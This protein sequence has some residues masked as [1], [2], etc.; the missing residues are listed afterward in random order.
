[1]SIL[2]VVAVL[3]AIGLIVRDS[4]QNSSNLLDNE[5]TKLPNSQDG[6]FQP[7]SQRLLDE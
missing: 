7:A 1:M 5:K 2:V 4:G 6:Y 3:L